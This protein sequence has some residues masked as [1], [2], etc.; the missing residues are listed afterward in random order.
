MADIEEREIDP[1]VNGHNELQLQSVGE[2]GSPATPRGWRYRPVHIGAIT[3]VYASPPTQLVLVALVCFL[4]PGMFN[5]L[6]GLGGGGQ[7]AAAA[8]DN[9]NVR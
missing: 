6:N 1:E 2:P 5:A 3:I 7:V 4:C 8:A 9:A